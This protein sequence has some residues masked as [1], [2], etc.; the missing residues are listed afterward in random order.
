MLC[1]PHLLRHGLPR[2]SISSPCS[3]AVQGVLVPTTLLYIENY[4]EMTKK[5]FPEVAE[6]FQDA[7]VWTLAD[8]FENDDYRSKTNLSYEYAMGDSW[9][10][11]ITFV[12]VEDP[13]PR[14][15]LTE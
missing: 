12:G 15:A 11:Q 6:K 14:Q 2:L 7:K 10:H 3:F 5:S 4:P 9:E 1:H 13:D 8:V